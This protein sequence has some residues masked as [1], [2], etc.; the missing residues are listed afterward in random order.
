MSAESVALP[1]W[2]AHEI[3]AAL[4][5]APVSSSTIE[6]LVRV[7]RTLG[8]RDGTGP[9]DDAQIAGYM[10]RSH[11]VGHRTGF[12]RGV[13]QGQET[14]RREAL[15]YAA[16]ETLRLRGIPLSERLRPAPCCNHDLA[17][18]AAPGSATRCDRGRLL[19][20]PAWRTTGDG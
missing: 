11:D 1:T 8:D 18:D 10:R 3:H 4:N 6:C 12:E 9:M 15:A 19:V 20:T 17:A 14:A 16:T 13:E 5:E 7:G 2:R